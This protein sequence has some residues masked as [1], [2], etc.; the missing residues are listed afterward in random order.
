MSELLMQNVNAYNPR[1]YPKDTPAEA[2]ARLAGFEAG[3]QYEASLRDDAPAIVLPLSV[4]VGLT[5][6][7]ET[8]LLSAPPLTNETS[9]DGYAHAVDAGE[10]AL[11][12]YRAAHPS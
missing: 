5:D 6:A 3:R 8:L 7:L 11:A 1:D 9:I 2:S 12:A 10:T 4:I